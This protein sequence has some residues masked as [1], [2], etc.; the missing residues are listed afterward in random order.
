MR[1]ST[2]TTQS[3]GTAKSQSLVCQAFVKSF[4]VS[5]KQSSKS[6]APTLLAL[7]LLPMAHHCLCQHQLQC[8]WTPIS[9]CLNPH[10][11]RKPELSRHVLKEEQWHSDHAC[12]RITRRRGRGEVPVPSTQSQYYPQTVCALTSDHSSRIICA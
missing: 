9:T 7:L 1:N 2:S 11:K 6:F 5:V 12:S 3:A 4:Q 10:S 8:P